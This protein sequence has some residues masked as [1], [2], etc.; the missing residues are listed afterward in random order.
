MIDDLDLDDEL[1]EGE[2]DEPSNTNRLNVPVTPHLPPMGRWAADAACKDADP[3]WFD[4]RDRDEPGLDSAEVLRN[5]VKAAQLC[6]GCP[7][8]AECLAD[9]RANQWVGVWGGRL[10]GIGSNTLEGRTRLDRPRKGVDLVAKYIGDPALLNTTLRKRAIYAR[11][12]AIATANTN[13][14]TKGT[15]A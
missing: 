3:T 2:L 13:T 14:D 5:Q 15:A 7:V 12:K 1:Q 6:A 11:N 9:A 4:L 8:R 10:F